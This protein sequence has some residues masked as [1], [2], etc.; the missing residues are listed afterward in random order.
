MSALKTVQFSMDW[1]THRCEVS[2]P[3]ARNRHPHARISITEV[4]QAI[5]VAVRCHFDLTLPENADRLVVQLQS[6]QDLTWNFEPFLA[7]RKG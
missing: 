7:S 6:M 3:Q 2:M 1:F 5:P 4:Q